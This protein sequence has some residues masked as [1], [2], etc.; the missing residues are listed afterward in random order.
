MYL[1]QNRKNK[2]I[3]LNIASQPN[4]DLKFRLFALL[5][6]DK[7]RHELTS[8]ETTRVAQAEK[9]VAKRLKKQIENNEN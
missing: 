1:L 4:I 7:L 3:L 2:Y 6:L 9:A 8:E 5:Y